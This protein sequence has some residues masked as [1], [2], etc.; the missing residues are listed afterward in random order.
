M[1]KYNFLCQKCFQFAFIKLNYK[2][3]DKIDIE[4]NN[5]KYKENLNLGEFL[6]RNNAIQN[7]CKEKIQCEEHNNCFFIYCNTCNR[8]LC[9]MCMDKHSKKHNYSKLKQYNII[10][11]EKLEFNKI[12]QY[13]NETVLTLK[14]YIIKELEIQIIN[15]NKAYEESKKL[16]D[17][18]MTFFSSLLNSYSP[19]YPHFIIEQNIKTNNP[20][21][22]NFY[23]LKAKN[24]IYKV[25]DYYK[26]YTIINVDISNFNEILQISPNNPNYIPNSLLLL[27]DGRLAVFGD[28]LPIKIFAL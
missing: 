14:D 7:L 2:L 24:D 6:K 13:Y 11:K 27:Q 25:I 17:T 21:R 20:F 22:F 4:C 3:K 26:S 18:L 5:C 8:H 12:Q 9:K 16:N 28:G 1:N 10:K 15:L 23:S 19:K